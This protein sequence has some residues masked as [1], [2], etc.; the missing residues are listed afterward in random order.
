MAVGQAEP[1]CQ[2]HVHG[3]GQ[4]RLQGGHHLPDPV[5]QEAVHLPVGP[6][7]SQLNREGTRG[8]VLVSAFSL[9]TF[10]FFLLSQL[11]ANEGWIL[12]SKRKGLTGVSRPW[13]YGR[14]GPDPFCCRLSSS[15]SGL[16]QAGASNTLPH[17]LL[18]QMSPGG[19]PG[20]QLRTIFLT[21]PY[22]KS[23]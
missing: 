20:L 3:L 12:L 9:F 1:V 7:S 5:F 10:F 16:S 22:F 18:C 17:K 19:S 2:P 23:F 4:P 14:L 8:A 6:Q 21:C 11:L 15:I 13:H